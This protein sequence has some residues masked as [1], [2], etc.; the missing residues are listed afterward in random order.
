M[1]YNIVTH[2]IYY[3]YVRRILCRPIDKIMENMV[4]GVILFSRK[5]RKKRYFS[6][7]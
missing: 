1:S 7:D 3:F 5:V 4:K 6:V 2:F